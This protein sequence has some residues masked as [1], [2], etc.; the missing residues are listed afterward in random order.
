MNRRKIELILGLLTILTAI[1]SWWS[2]ARIIE[3]NGSSSWI[4]SM[5]F[6]IVFLTLI[7]LDIVLFKDIV[8]LELLLLSSMISGIIF[9]GGWWH[10]LGLLVGAYF[11]LLSSRKIR[12]DFELNVKIDFLKSLRTGKFFLIMAFSVAIAA[13]Y[14]SVIRLL[15][16]QILIPRF[17]TGDISNKVTFKIL[18]S[19][20]PNFKVLENENITV[21][22]FILQSQ[23][24][25]IDKENQSFL[26][27]NP[28]QIIKQELNIQNLSIEDQKEIQQQIKEKMVA[29]SFELNAEEQQLLLQESR[30]QLSLLVGREVQGTEKISSL[31]SDL[32]GKKI[33]NAL[34]P[35]VAGQQ[36]SSSVAVVLAGI[37]FLTVFSI[38]S[39]LGVIVFFLSWCVFKIMIHF[40]LL[41]IETMIVEKEMIA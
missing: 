21:D 6:F 23:K 1:F 36:K 33:E 7:C 37:L 24:N 14:F 9:I 28:T 34:S 13:Q 27:L 8:Y 2:V 25:Q 30:R 5:A 35:N 38:G 18:S 4:F 16:G 3:V 10:A 39:L 40:S 15:D 29:M 32:I 41:K 22:E 17:E 26:D 11:L 12:R 20:D 19:F 31:I